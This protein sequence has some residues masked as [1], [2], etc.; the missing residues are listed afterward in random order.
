M[1]AEKAA[2]LNSNST[3]EEEDIPRLTSDQPTSPLDERRDPS[4]SIVTPGDG[5]TADPL[6]STTP[7]GREGLSEKARGKLRAVE[8]NQDRAEGEGM[9][10]VEDEELMKVAS[11]GVG[12]GGYVPTQEWV[13][14]WQKG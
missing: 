4:L 12:P 1:L 8:S 5:N 7:T 6:A 2:L 3:T 14:S 13:S 10:D 9:V 11:A